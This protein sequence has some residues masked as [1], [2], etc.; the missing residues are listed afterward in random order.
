MKKR[1]ISVLSCLI[2][3][4]SCLPE[5]VKSPTQGPR[6]YSFENRST[7]EGIK[8][9]A[10]FSVP[11]DWGRWVDGR[12]CNIEFE[13]PLQGL[14]KLQVWGGALGGNKGK[15]ILVT[16][17]NATGYL[18]F[19]HDPFTSAELP[20]VLELEVSPP[21]STVQFDAP[22]S[23]KPGNG[24]DRLLSFGVKKIIIEGK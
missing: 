23:E 21:A 19:D 10:G 13:Q 11:E 17:G 2:F 14:V 15:D 3:L 4:V 5:G 12:P 18:R 8:S 1:V 7:P 22:L 20:A 16:I 9:L 24:D 6:T